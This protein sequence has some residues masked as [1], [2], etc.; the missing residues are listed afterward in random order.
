[1]SSSCSWPSPTKDWSS[2][3]RDS[4]PRLCEA[5]QHQRVFRHCEYCSLEL[6]KHCQRGPE[7]ARN[8]GWLGTIFN[9]GNS[10][11]ELP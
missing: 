8:C 7:Q 9:V 2:S 1:M 11:Q 4:K 10:H 5:G 6:C 3:I